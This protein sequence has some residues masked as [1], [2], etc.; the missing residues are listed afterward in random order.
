MFALRGV[1]VSLAFF[2]VLYCLLSALVVMAWRWLKLA[3]TRVHM[4]EQSLADLL[5]ALRI[6]P[7]VAA[8]AITVAFVVPSFQLLEPRSIHEGMGF[9]PLALGLCALFLIAWG[10]F[11]VIAAQT[12]ASRMVARWLQGSRMMKSG[13]AMMLPSRSDAPPIAVV[14][15]RKPRVLVSEATVAILTPDELSIA[16]RHELAHVRSHDNLK[17]LIF[18]FCSFPGMSRL[19]DAW[20]HTAELA[21]DDMAVSKMDEAVDLAAAL[22]KLSRVIPKHAAPACT[23]GLI[24]GSIS[25]R[26]ARLLAWDG[27][28]KTSLL[29]LRARYVF[30]PAFVTLLWV[31]ATYRPVL[32][33]THEATEWLVR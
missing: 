6:L 1:A 3:D 31:I 16:L 33:L 32:A 10:C 21:A 2:V 26:V 4:S 14:G 30:A 12:T 9:L 11:R 24:T 8:V 15:V 18:R 22:V 28:H 29:H 13:Q 23:I 19:E 27:S 17:K 5:F 7:V 25:A 20:S